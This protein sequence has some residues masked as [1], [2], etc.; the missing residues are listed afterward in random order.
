MTYIINS[1]AF[2][3]SNHLR[4]AEG[5]YGEIEFCGIKSKFRRSFSR[6]NII[7]NLMRRNL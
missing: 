1:V 7:Y 5:N 6:S 4:Q 2:V 3:F